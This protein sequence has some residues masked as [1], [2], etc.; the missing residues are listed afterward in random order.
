MDMNPPITK[1]EHLL[2]DKLMP[3]QAKQIVTRT[4]GEGNIRLIT[5][6][7]DFIRDMDLLSFPATGRGQSGRRSLFARDNLHHPQPNVISMMNK[8]RMMRG[9]GNA[10]LIS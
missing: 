4:L 8:W 5:R 6:K 7:N 9:G 10:K 3:L 1:K 2:L